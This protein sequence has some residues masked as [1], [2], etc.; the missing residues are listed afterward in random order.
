MN[1]NENGIIKN[2]LKNSGKRIKQQKIGLIK[3]QDSKLNPHLWVF[4]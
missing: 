3:N 2:E 1:R 4:Y